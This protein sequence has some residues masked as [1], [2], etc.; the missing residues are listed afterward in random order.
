MTV[1]ETRESLGIDKLFSRV[2]TVDGE[3]LKKLGMYIN[4]K[5]DERMKITATVKSLDEILKSGEVVKI[6]SDGCVSFKDKGYLPMVTQKMCGERL[7]FDKLDGWYYSKGSIFEKEWLKDIEEVVDWENIEVDTKVITIGDRSGTEY[8][9]HFKEF[10]NGKII[11]FGNG[12]T[13]FSTDGNCVRW[14]VE[15]VKLYKGK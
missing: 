9:L 10:K 5:G 12:R 6:D 13:S 7:E 4:N 8:K 2:I 14:G 11:T 1:K 3:R 15:D